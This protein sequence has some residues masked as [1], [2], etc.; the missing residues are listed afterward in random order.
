MKKLVFIM[1]VVI[2]GYAVNASA[3]DKQ[4]KDAKKTTTEQV[5]KNHASTT[6]DKVFPGRK[7]RMVSQFMLVQREVSII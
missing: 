4:Q 2:L 7:V 1:A 3:V 5:K 6:T